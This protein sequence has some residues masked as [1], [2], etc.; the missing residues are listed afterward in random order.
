L[1]D[2]H[3]GFDTTYLKRESPVWVELDQQYGRLVVLAHGSDLVVQPGWE[4][5]TEGV[6]ER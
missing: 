1:E 5:S 2:F 4:A 6:E 3:D